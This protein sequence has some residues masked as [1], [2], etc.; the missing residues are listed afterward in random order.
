M[1]KIVH[2]FLLIA[3]TY[4]AF[5]HASSKFSIKDNI[6]AKE[7]NQH[8]NETIKIYGTVSGGRPLEKSFLTLI[9]VEGNY[10]NHA[11]TIMIKDTD[12][13]K[14]SYAPETFLKGKKIVA[15]GKVVEYMGEARDCYYG[16]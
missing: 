9:N 15:T 6:P 14:F 1:R 2:I 8:Y 16:S 3:F 10:P 13:K 12:R 11:L 7:A 4:P 5:S